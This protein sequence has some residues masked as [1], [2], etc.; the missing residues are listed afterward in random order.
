MQIYKEGWLRKT[1][2]LVEAVKRG[3]MEPMAA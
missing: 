3:L 1:A 2:E